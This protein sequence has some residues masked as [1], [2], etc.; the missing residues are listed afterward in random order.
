MKTT[1]RIEFYGDY[2]YLDD[3][4]CTDFVASDIERLI[5]NLKSDLHYRWRGSVKKIIVNKKVY[6]DFEQAWEAI[7]V[8][9]KEIKNYE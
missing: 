5:G 9:A 1:L 7:R 2:G 4:F 6:T 3:H 8:W